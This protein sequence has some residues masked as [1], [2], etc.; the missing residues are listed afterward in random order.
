MCLKEYLEKYKVLTLELMDEIK[1]DGEIGIFIKK[2]EEILNL[3]SSLDFEKEEIRTI[4]D[5]LN[6]LKLEEEIH[7]L[8]N[9]ERI[10]VKRQIDNIKRIKKANA[11]Y[12]SFENRA[13]VFNKMI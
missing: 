4:S 3:V 5:S 8:V 10:E 11:N 12:N 13:M 1:R 7:K 2:R 9:K 6:L